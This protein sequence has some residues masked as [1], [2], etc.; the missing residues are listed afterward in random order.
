MD[1]S[2]FYFHQ[3][4][5]IIFSKPFIFLKSAH[6]TRDLIIIYRISIRCSKKMELRK[7]KLIQAKPFPRWFFMHA[8]LR[9]LAK[10]DEVSGMV[11]KFIV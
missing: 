8:Y 1:E 4:M 5:I 3:M 9:F 2:K 11:S 7:A 6:N 10:E